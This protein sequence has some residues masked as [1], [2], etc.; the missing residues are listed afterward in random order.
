MTSPAME[1]AV[2]YAG[3]GIAVFPLRRKMKTPY[4]RTTTLKMASAEPA[5]ATERVMLRS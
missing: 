4:G 5:L 2:R 3:L 1:A